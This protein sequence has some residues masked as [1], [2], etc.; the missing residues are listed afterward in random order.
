MTS[1]SFTK[2]QFVS[3]RDLKDEKFYKAKVVEV[4]DDQKSVRVHY[5]R[6]D[7]RY[8][9]VIPLSSARIMEWQSG[10]DWSSGAAKISTE[11]KPLNAEAV[12]GGS[13][14]SVCGRVLGLS[15][16]AMV[17]IGFDVAMEQTGGWRGLW[18][19]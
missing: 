11:E 2:G 8:D 13:T 16:G 7:S 15:R 18:V 19:L 1:L 12:P 10:G 5:I 6:W 3:V 9:E 14:G 4:D 17:G